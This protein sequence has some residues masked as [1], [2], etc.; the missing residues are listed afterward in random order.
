VERNRITNRAVEINIGI[1]LHW[2]NKALVKIHINKMFDI[3]AKKSN[4]NLPELY[5][6]L[7]PETN[8]LSPSAKSKGAR[9][10]SEIIVISHIR[11]RGKLRSPRGNLPEDLIKYPL[12]SNMIVNR[13]K[14]N[15]IS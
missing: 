14:I 3:S 9:L 11:R 15:E 13:K 10:V 2:K 12:P 4:P 1:T 7:N 6:M 5:S 8:S